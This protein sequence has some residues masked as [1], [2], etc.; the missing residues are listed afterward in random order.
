MRV[1]TKR[2]KIKR[3]IKSVI[4]NLYYFGTLSKRILFG[5]NINIEGRVFLSSRIKLDD[6]VELRNLTKEDLSIDSGTAINR[7]TVIRGKVQI[8]KNVGI[9]PNC[10][11]I[12]SNHVFSDPNSDIKKQ[13]SRQLGVIIQDDV[14]VGANTVILD[15]VT[16]GTKSIIGAGSVVTK[17]IPSYSIAVGNPCRV[18]KVR[19]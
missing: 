8:G 12:G 5:D 13:G 19:E 4:L 17:S 15:G 7:N 10:M 9:A 18:I 2:R 16:I 11:I 6:N 1:N 14:W 3:A